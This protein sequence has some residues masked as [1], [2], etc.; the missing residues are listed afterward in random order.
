MQKQEKRKNHTLEKIKQSIY[1][2]ENE[3]GSVTNESNLHNERKLSNTRL[4]N[5]EKQTRK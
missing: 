1:N 3:K 4:N 5:R 2:K